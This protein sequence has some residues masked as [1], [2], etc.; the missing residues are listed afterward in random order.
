M[1]VMLINPYGAKLTLG[2]EEGDENKLEDK[3]IS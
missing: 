3:G 2:E 1:M